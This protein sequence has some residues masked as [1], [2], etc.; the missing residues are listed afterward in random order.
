MVCSQVRNDRPA[1]AIRASRR[2]GR[3]D[4]EERGIAD[5]VD[6]RLAQRVLQQEVRSHEGG[7][8][9]CDRSET[10]HAGPTPR[11]VPLRPRNRQCNAEGYLALAAR[12]K[13]LFRQGQKARAA[14][15]DR[16]ADGDRATR[17]HREPQPILH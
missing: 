1:L 17:R 7:G 4:S 8:S 5:N 9:R 10:F 12:C 6:D 2:N 16:A 15:L 3:V 13:Q 14:L 11:S